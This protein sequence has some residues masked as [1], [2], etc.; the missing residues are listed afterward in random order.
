M[1]KFILLLFFSISISGYSQETEN[2]SIATQF[3]N[4][5]TGSFESNAQWY[6]NDK[7][8]GDFSDPNF[9]IEDEPLRAN[10]YFRLDYN[11]L[12]NFS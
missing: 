2:E 7:E 3:L 10:T 11:F 6:T 5:L 9:P 12:K 1:K 4:N 8:L